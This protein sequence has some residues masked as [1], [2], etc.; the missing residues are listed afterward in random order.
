MDPLTKLKAKIATQW[1][2]KIEAAISHGVTVLSDPNSPAEAYDAIQKELQ[3]IHRKAGMD[4]VTAYYAEVRRILREKLMLG[5]MS[6]EEAARF[7]ESQLARLARAAPSFPKSIP[8]AMK[9]LK[10]TAIA[11]G[12]ALFALALKAKFDFGSGV[13]DE[14]QQVQQQ[15]ELDQM[16][17]Q[18][19]NASEISVEIGGPISIDDTASG[20][21]QAQVEI[22]QEVAATPIQVVAANAAPVAMPAA[23]VIAALARPEDQEK[24]VLFVQRANNEH[25]Q[26]EFT[27]SPPRRSNLPTGITGGSSFGSFSFTY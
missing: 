2:P 13:H 19:E 5:G 12:L 25:R 18:V 10:R 16:R 3:E 9:W 6:A 14:L 21:V 27:E 4:A 17:Q 22:P 23:R 24:A 1:I 11:A 8:K 26:V 7:V 20:A 15:S